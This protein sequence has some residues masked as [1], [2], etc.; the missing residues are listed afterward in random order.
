MPETRKQTPTFRRT[1]VL[2][3]LFSALL[4]VPLHSADFYVAPDGDDSNP[5]SEAQPFQTLEAARDAIRPLIQ[6]GLTRDIEVLIR[7]GT[8]RMTETVVFGLEDSGTVDHRIIYKAYPNE[9]PVFSAG[10]PVTGWAL[11]SDPDDNPEL[12]VADLPAE[13]TWP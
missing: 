5:G 3:T 7:G 4:T 12:Y 13:C 8:Y 10:F 2:T 1:V 6:A 11:T 9:E